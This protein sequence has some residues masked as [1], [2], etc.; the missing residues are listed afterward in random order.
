MISSCRKR[1]RSPDTDDTHCPRKQRLRRTTESAEKAKRSPSRTRL[2][3]CL[4]YSDSALTESA[5]ETI[6]EIVIDLPP[7]PESSIAGFTPPTAALQSLTP[8]QSQVRQSAVHEAYTQG[9]DLRQTADA[10]LDQRSTEPSPYTTPEPTRW[11]PEHVYDLYDPDFGSR[12]RSQYRVSQRRHAC[13]ISIY[14]AEV[15]NT[16][17]RGSTPETARDQ[18]KAHL[19]TLPE[20]MDSDISDDGSESNTSDDLEAEAERLSA[21]LLDFPESERSRI[22]FIAGQI[23]MTHSDGRIEKVGEIR[24]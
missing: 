9:P 3:S 24:R 2:S 8:K 5:D 18:W 12:V 11:K 23:F 21:A 6:S 17:K 14:G 15:A 16:W 4:V 20:I 7:T 1:K 22:F 13:R 19:E 10:Q